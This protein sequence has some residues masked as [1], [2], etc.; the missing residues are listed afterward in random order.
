MSNV[1]VPIPK[2]L[3]VELSSMCNAL[4]LGCVRTNLENFNNVRSLIPKKDI[5]S[6]ETWTKVIEGFTD[7]GL[8]E[9][10]F[11]GTIDDPLMHPDFL[12]V[13]KIALEI[14]PDLIVRIHSNAS[15]RNAEYFSELANILNK[16]K[17]HFFYFSIDG[18]EDTNHLYRQKTSYIKIIEN[19]ESFIKANGYAIW[20]FIS[21]LWNKHQSDEAREISKKMGFKEFHLRHDRT[22]NDRTFEEIKF[23]K[24]INQNTIDNIFDFHFID[25]ANLKI[26]DKIE[27]NNQKVNMFFL[28][29]DGLLW[30]CCFLHNA[31][32][33]NKSKRHLI[34]ERTLNLYG[35]GWN[36]CNKH[37]ISNILNHRFYTNDLI[38]SW[39]STNHGSGLTDR[40]YRCTE[41]CSVST[42]GAKPIGNAKIHINE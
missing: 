26:E 3:Q 38:K 27:C 7:K 25:N 10:E 32:F 1:Y 8:L 16:F 21:F 34:D 13:L 30:P 12:K 23:V 39:K 19:A 18:L 15:I 33:I 41:T 36:D 29:H 20:Q 4:C 2:K 17:Q 5:L 11:C 42:L 9:I 6:L 14:N 40:I 28:G 24:N 37:P 31:R 22:L 35:T